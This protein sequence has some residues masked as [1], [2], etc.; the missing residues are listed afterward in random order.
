[1]EQ[2]KTYISNFISSNVLPLGVTVI[3]AGLVLA[4]LAFMGGKK[5][6]DWAKEHILFII[7]GAAILYTA[8]SIATDFAK[9]FGF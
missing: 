5:G 2:L 4:A 1:M 8:T 7:I 3:T 9:S 6:R